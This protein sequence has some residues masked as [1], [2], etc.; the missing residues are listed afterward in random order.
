MG[1]RGGLVVISRYPGRASGRRRRLLR[2][3]RA[4]DRKMRDLSDHHAVR[5]RE[6]EQ[7]M[8]VLA[9][10]MKP[11][12]ARQ[13]EGVKAIASLCGV[14]ERTIREWAARAKDPLPIEGNGRRWAYLGALVAWC[15]RN[16]VAVPVPA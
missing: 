6:L 12:G 1:G 3:I 16:G 7:Q 8:A 9:E 15:R 11:P 4:Y 5:I 14:T 2:L 13:I 10:R